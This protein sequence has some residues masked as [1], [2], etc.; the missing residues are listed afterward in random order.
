MRSFRYSRE[1]G[2]SH[3]PLVKHR[4]WRAPFGLSGRFFGQTLGSMSKETT[5]NNS[6][7]S[8]EEWIGRLSLEEKIRLIHG[9]GCF[10]VA[11]V[12]RHGIEDLVLSDGPHGVRMETHYDSFV[13]IGNCDDATTYLP[14]GIAL[15]AT[16]N[17]TR[18]RD[19]GDVLGAEA[20]ARGK[21]VI[22]GPGINLIRTPLCGRNFEYFGED[23]WHVGRMAV[24][25]VKG[26][27]RHDVAANVKHFA[28][29]NQE[30]DRHGVDVSIDER[31]LRELYLRAF[32]M[33]VKEGGCLTVMGAYN[34]LRGTHCCHHAELLQAILKDEWG[35]QGFVVS[36]W[37]GVHDTE[38]VVR[39]GLDLEMGGA[40]GEHHLDKPFRRGLEEGRYSMAWL[41]EKVRRILW[42]H[43]QIGKLGG[44]APRAKGERLT[45]KHRAVAKAIA[46]EAL[47]LLKNDKQALPLGA[48][49]LR[50][51]A[52][53]GDNATRVHAAGGGSSGIRAEY[54]VTPLE[55]LREA[56]GR[57]VELIVVPGYPVKPEGVEPI[58]LEC[59][60][61]ADQAGIRGWRR[62]VYPNRSMSGEPREAAVLPEIETPAD[63]HPAGLAVGHW[64]HVY[65]G[66]V[67]PEKTGPHTLVARGGDYFEV[68]WD[69]TSIFSV[70]D[71]TAATTETLSIELEAG[72][73]YVVEIRYRP[74]VGAHGFS[75]GWIPP[76]RMETSTDPF[77]EAVAAAEAADAVLFFGGS[78]HRQDTEGVDRGSMQLPGGQ[79]PLIARLAEANPRCVV[80]LFGGSAV[81]M[82]WLDHVSA[83]LQAWYPGQEGGRALADV[84][85]GKVNPSGHLPF[86]WPRR[87]ADVPAHARGEYGA[88]HIRYAEGL[89][90]G[91]RWHDGPGPDPLFPFGHGLSY[92]SF[93]M[94]DAVLDASDPEAVRLRTRVT[95]TG[96]RS[97]ATLVQAYVRSP[98]GPLGHAPKTLAAFAKVHLAPGASREI[99][100]EINAR[101]RSHYDPRTKSWVAPRGKHTFHLAWN[102]AEI[103]ETLTADF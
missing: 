45:P 29:N 77:A 71:Q 92:T 41:D 102:A 74:K 39:P 47:V 90:L 48:G 94:A 26:I 72:R 4:L 99:D 12:P 88:G 44:S 19:F 16:W 25:V 63:A 61:V 24:A 100:L 43:Q 57:E 15:A 7:R 18:A 73:S 42:V 1:R 37:G 80:V 3:S 69:G 34:R 23:P 52:V 70:W 17:E 79:D 97:G 93:A 11:G 60:G 20:R 76:G 55:G 81:D 84:L 59:L 31:P 5:A 32:E 14:V 66:T 36:D 54:E 30:L 75:F 103:V 98:D 86:T 33:A 28:C 89:H 56:F 49:A 50:R 64:M 51:V 96:S 67:T 101:A 9:D 62:V 21:D 13:P 38:Q 8:L 58:P 53:I 87:L 27:Q 82:P 91:Y 40:L 6:P 83:V 46:D 10:T 22:L 68:I 78:S 65:Q 95:N 85:L 2:K 35:F